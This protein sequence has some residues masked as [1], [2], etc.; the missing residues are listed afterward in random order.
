MTLSLTIQTT[1]SIFTQT[2]G[3]LPSSATIVRRPPSRSDRPAFLPPV[4]RQ[5]GRAATYR[6]GDG[7]GRSRGEL[8]LL[9]GAARGGLD[10]TG[11]GLDTAAEEDARRLVELRVGRQHFLQ[12]SL[13]VT[14]S[15]RCHGNASHGTA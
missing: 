4:R 1:N 9:G 2:F 5:L 3:S 12:L 10:T 8:L 14:P 6:R 7:G 11:G 15:N 13:P